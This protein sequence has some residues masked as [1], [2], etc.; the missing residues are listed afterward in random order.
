M[1]LT[2]L[3]PQPHRYLLLPRFERRS[4]RFPPGSTRLRVPVPVLPI[5]RVL[6]RPSPKPRLQV[7]DEPLEAHATT[8]NS[9]G[10]K[11]EVP[12]A[13]PESSVTTAAAIGQTILSGENHEWKDNNGESALNDQHMA[14]P[15]IKRDD[16]SYPEHSSRGLLAQWVKQA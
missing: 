4:R 15:V 16:R 1:I 5:P 13:A 3:R 11:P 6:L 7:P 2:G 10:K 8:V 14:S 9:P 12:S